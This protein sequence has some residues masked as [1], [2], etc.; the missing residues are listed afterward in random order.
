M[1]QQNKMKETKPSFEH[2]Q[3]Q[4]EKPAYGQ[5]FSP[6]PN[7]IDMDELVVELTRRVNLLEQKRT[8]LNTDIIG[9]FE[10]VTVAPTGVPFNLFQQIKI[11]KISGTSYLYIYDTLNHVWLRVVIA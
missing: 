8:N 3:S 5:V 6:I 7:N 1:I 10:T 2:P 9:M 11:A 4:S